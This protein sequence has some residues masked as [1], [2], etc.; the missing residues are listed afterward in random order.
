MIYLSKKFLISF[1]AVVIL[2]TFVLNTSAEKMPYAT[3][4]TDRTLI[5]EII[6]TQKEIREDQKKM[7]KMLK[8][9]QKSIEEI[10]K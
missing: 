10:S 7:L 2:A 4:K 5:K 1:L 8:D 9:M 6:V 3:N